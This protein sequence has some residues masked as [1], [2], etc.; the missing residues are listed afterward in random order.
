MMR[1]HMIRDHIRC[2]ICHAVINSSKPIFQSRINYGVICS[3]CMEIFSPEEI[4]ISLNLFIL[5]GGY[6]GQYK[7]E[8]FSLIKRLLEIIENE[9][10]DFNIETTNM[11]L[12]HLA[13]IHGITPQEFNSSLKSFLKN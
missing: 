6:F 1:D 13:L 2:A 10:K 11:K 7:Q 12:L 3:R 8:K 9:G 4:E 5:Y